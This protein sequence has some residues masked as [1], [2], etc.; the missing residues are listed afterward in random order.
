[1]SSRS[2]AFIRLRVTGSRVDSRASFRHLGARM[3]MTE[4]NLSMSLSATAIDHLSP[5]CRSL[6]PAFPNG[7][8][9]TLAFKCS[10]CVLSHK[11][12]DLE[13]HITRGNH[14]AT[15]VVVDGKP[16]FA[17]HFPELFAGNSEFFPG[18]AHDRSALLAVFCI[19]SFGHVRFIAHYMCAVKH[20]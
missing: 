17:D 13:Q 12:H 9:K 10:V 1:M 2:S 8:D 3:G 4:S 7:R 6:P 15:F 5:A 14:P 20:I 19:G 11:I 16:V 18:V